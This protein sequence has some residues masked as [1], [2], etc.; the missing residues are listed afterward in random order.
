MNLQ[1][2]FGFPSVTKEFKKQSK[3]WRNQIEAIEVYQIIEQLLAGF[4]KR[5]SEC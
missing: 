3:V 4:I 5:V 2:V 1:G